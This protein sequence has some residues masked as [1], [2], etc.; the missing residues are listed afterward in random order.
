MWTGW[1]LSNTHTGCPPLRVSIKEL[2]GVAEEGRGYGGTSVA[3]LQSA[4]LS[5][6]KPPYNTEDSS[7]FTGY[8][9]DP[10]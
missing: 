5:V 3:G 1:F 2:P 6:W 8:G 10:H 4:Q 7:N 9:H